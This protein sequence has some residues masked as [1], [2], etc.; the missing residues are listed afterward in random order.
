ML[1][2]PDQITLDTK[3]RI[4]KL[5]THSL[6]FENLH[7]ELCNTNFRAT[8]HCQKEKSKQNRKDWW[9]KSFTAANQRGFFSVQQLCIIILC[10]SL[11]ELLIVLKRI[12][13]LQTFRWSFLKTRLKNNR[14]S[15]ELSKKDRF[16][17]S[18]QRTVSCLFS[19]PILFSM[20][21]AASDLLAPLTHLSLPLWRNCWYIYMDYSF[22][23]YFFLFC[24]L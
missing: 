1:V 7:Y 14:D 10:M 3:I 16:S 4:C 23:R 15:S 17:Y 21:L 12:H 13:V 9:K 18:F 19:Y 8:R 6:L 5:T 24:Y 11:V 20:L 22:V 2:S